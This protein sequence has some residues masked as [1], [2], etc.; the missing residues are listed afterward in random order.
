[1]ELTQEIR[2]VL[3]ALR[4][5]GTHVRIVEKLDR[6]TYQKVNEVLETAGGKWSRGAK[7]H[8]FPTD[9]S[10]K[11][12]ELSSAAEVFTAKEKKQSDGWFATPEDLADRLVRIAMVGA[13]HMVLEPSAGEGAIVRA[14]RR[15]RPGA[16]ITAVELDDV[17]A[18]KIPAVQHLI[19][20]DFLQMGKTPNLF[21]RVIMNPPFVKTSHLDHVE[22]A[23]KQL[24][25][26]GRLVSV[27][28]QGVKDR[29]NKRHKA[30]RAA[31]AQ[32]HYEI[33]DLPDDAFKASGT[34]VRTC[35]LIVDIVQL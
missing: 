4:I 1:M 27:L 12:A 29:Q 25:A 6:K 30:F 8:V 34:N 9:P 7:A 21:H 31:L 14:I 22:H 32:H 5:D 11:L 20:G 28:P 24:R 35:A 19:L 18:Q 33:V 23:L 3:G 10:D 16:S 26:K 13:D 2:S 15:A 17:R